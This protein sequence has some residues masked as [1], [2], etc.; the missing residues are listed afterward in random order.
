MGT[1]GGHQREEEGQSPD[2]VGRR[3]RVP[4]S[5]EHEQN[6]GQDVSRKFEETTDGEIDVEVTWSRFLEYF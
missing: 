6:C 3:L 1:W 4:S 2:D 5:H